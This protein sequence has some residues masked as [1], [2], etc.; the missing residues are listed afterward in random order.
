MTDENNM[1][2]NNI[3]VMGICVVKVDVVVIISVELKVHKTL[4][5]K[6]QYFRCITFYS[7]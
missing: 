6:H 3:D 5:F 7:F 4:R 2:I 1:V